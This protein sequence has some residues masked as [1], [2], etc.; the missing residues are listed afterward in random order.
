VGK[1]QKNGVQARAFRICYRVK[2]V[3]NT[4]GRMLMQRLSVAEA[5]KVL[6]ISVQA[7][8]GRVNRGTIQHERE[9]GKIYVFLTDDEVGD[10]HTLNSDVHDV[11]N[12]YIT[13]LRSEIESLKEDREEWKEEARRKDTIIAQM[14]QT[15]GAMIHR[16]PELEAPT[17][18]S[19]EATE[20][21]VT[22]TDGQG[23]GAVSPEPQNGSER[24]SWWRRLF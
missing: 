21:R 5:A 13:S 2:G 20:H 7:V 22:D 4:S 15:L 1:L 9:D 14:N 11:Y 8:H 6:G 24:L 17:D 18:T 16:I 12:A 19:P 10:Q 23:K 3:V